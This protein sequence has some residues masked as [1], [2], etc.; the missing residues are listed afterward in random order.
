MTK[1]TTKAPSKAAAISAAKKS[2]VRNPP[3]LGLSHGQRD[4]IVS[5]HTKRRVSA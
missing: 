2:L 4:A 1:S 5:R 3:K